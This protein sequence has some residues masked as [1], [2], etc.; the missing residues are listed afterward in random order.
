MIDKFDGDYA[1]LSNF[2]ENEVILYGRTYKNA[3][4]AYQAQK[5]FDLVIKNQFQELEAGKAKKLGRNID[6]RADWEEVKEDVMEYVIRAKFSD[7]KLQDLLISTGEEELVEGNH[8]NDTYWG[9]CRGVGL[10]QLG[11]II[12]KIRNELVI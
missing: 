9:V 10:N 12:M 11:K 6:L 2:Y 5:T 1:F 8:W 4:A 7:P 3:E